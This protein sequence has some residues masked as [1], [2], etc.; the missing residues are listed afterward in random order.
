[1]RQAQPWYAKLVLYVLEEPCIMAPMMNMNLATIATRIDHLNAQAAIYR[2]EMKMAPHGLW[3]AI[4]ELL[5]KVEEELYR[6]IEC[7][8]ILSR[9]AA[10]AFES[11]PIRFTDDVV[12][13]D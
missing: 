1:M 12:A 2:R 9:R 7:H 4:N 6:M 5:F 13:T 3:L 8:R 10:A 11:A